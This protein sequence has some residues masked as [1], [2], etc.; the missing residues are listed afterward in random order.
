MD[1]SI[2]EY[3]ELHLANV[4]EAAR[5]KGLAVLV[6]A[7]SSIA[8]G[9]PGWN[10]FLES[11][12]KPLA[13][14]LLASVLDEL[15]QRDV[16][17]R[18]DR[19]AAHLADQYQQIFEQTFRPREVPI[20]PPEWI[21]LIYDLPLRLLLTTNYTDE[22]ERAAQF[23][24]VEGVRWYQSA[25]L[26]RALRSA[27][28]RT[29]LVY[30]HGRYNDRVGMETDPQGLQWSQ[31]ILGAKS[32]SYA[33][34]S[35]GSVRKNFSAICRT[36]T[37]L[38]L[39]ASLTD[40]DVNHTL[41]DVMAGSPGETHYAVLP[42]GRGK[43]PDFLAAEYREL[44]GV[45]PI[46][47]EHDGDRDT[48]LTALMQ[49]LVKRTES[50]SHAEMQVEAQVERGTARESAP[51][52]RVVHPLLRAAYFEPRP[53]YRAAIDDFLDAD[54]GGVLALIGV[55]GAGKTALV[56]EAIDPI[57]RGRI[58]RKLGGV[59]VWSFYVEPSAEAFFRS[60]ANYLTRKKMPVETTEL[61]ALQAVQNAMPVDAPVILVLDGLEKLQSER[62][63]A[64]R[65]T[66]DNTV[67]RTF[68]LWLA[69]IPAPARAI[70]TTRFPLPDLETE[71]GSD[72]V[73]FV[74][75]DLLTR[76]QARSLLRRRGVKGSDPELNAILDHFG[77]HALT[78]D[79]LGGLIATYLDGD[80]RQFRAIG[81]SEWTR[82]EVSQTTKTI[83]H[84][85][86]A[87]ERY[88][89]R[90]EPEVLDT[91]RRVAIYRQT[92]AI[93][94][95]L[96]ALG[97]R[98][99]Q[100]ERVRMAMELRRRLHRLTTLRLV[101]EER[102]DGEEYY[103]IH[104]FLQDAIVHGMGESRL[105]FVRAAR[106][107]VEASLESRP[108][109]DLRDSKTRNFI[110]QLIFFRADEGDVVLAYDLYRQRLGSYRQ[111]AWHH[112]E[113]GI[114]E[115]VCRRLL[116]AAAE[117]RTLSHSA[118]YLLRAELALYL[119]NLGRLGE[120]LV[121]F[122]ETLDYAAARAEDPRLEVRLHNVSQ[123]YLLAGQLPEASRIAKLAL[124]CADE[125][126]SD[127]ETIGALPWHAMALFELGRIGEA[128]VQFAHCRGA[129]NRKES[130]RWFLYSTRG[131]NLQ[132]ALLRCD[133][134]NEAR[135]Q[136][137]A[138]RE[139]HQREEW[140]DSI[141]RS[142]LT[143]AEA[144]RR[145]GELAA[146]R[147]SLR[148]AREFAITAQHQ[149]LLIHARLFGSRLERDAG[150]FARARLEAEDGLRIADTCGFDLLRVELCN[151][152]AE[153]RL[154]DGNANEALDFA[155]RALALTE[156]EECSWF[157]G[158]LESHEML[159][160][161]HEHLGDPGRALPHTRSAAALRARVRV[162]D[163]MLEPLLVP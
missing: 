143:L 162:T 114:G 1:W 139:I 71:E 124:Q 3:N 83:Q 69:Q 24:K 36:H 47:Y 32:Y 31:V 152:I 110:V 42:I 120:A 57:L 12:E 38:V 156:R 117:Q 82:F 22:I 56:R 11:L 48:P 149:E 106:E 89:Q 98:T 7:G 126:R 96:A 104:P 118:I 148:S 157:W 109:F 131:F 155:T 9:Y 153:L 85:L 79:H 54:E 62:R 70:V 133:R 101:H 66:L 80:A 30:L 111:L 102:I 160:R 136:A 145:S 135:A 2:A 63:G 163:A 6:G 40:A 50:S 49:D 55:G 28:G 25:Q 129:Q 53:L 122:R 46:F 41:R 14:I 115:S 37:L 4:A 128:F 64:V 8:C 87:Y 77:T 39:G 88:L 72:R 107:S 100:A 151:A 140:P 127:E 52:P 130:N 78:I 74:D 43:P 108:G 35:P 61:K 159:G 94:T 21:R 150:D 105:D 103:S 23:T 33:Y 138:A 137:A 81:R 154:L 29:S 141:A 93:A 91:L 65:G 116:E 59:F 60:L 121:Y 5:H 13:K 34:N 90:D 144:L 45:Q 20:D 51:F 95:L 15:R 73:R 158:E 18:L 26:A 58:A 17:T 134:V 112:A 123:A 125:Q 27:D 92:V 75:V 10:E 146:A 132:L 97:G 99:D 161:I 86:D 84:V 113:Y 44:W 67:L 76:P 119:E 142:D 147:E 68:L 19:M 16:R